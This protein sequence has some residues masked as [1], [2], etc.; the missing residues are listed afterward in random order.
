MA[1]RLKTYF[2]LFLLIGYL[3]VQGTTQGTSVHENQNVLEL[4]IVQGQTDFITDDDVLNSSIIPISIENDVNL[5]D[6]NNYTVSVY[7]NH[8]ARFADVSF[9]LRFKNPTG[10]E[11]ETFYLNHPLLSYE[12]NFL[13]DSQKNSGNYPWGFED[14]QLNYENMT[15]NNNNA[16]FSIFG[17]A[18]NGKFLQKILHLFH[19]FFVNFSL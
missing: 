4:H 13:T 9:M 6:L 11:M 16:N 3:A 14:I 19:Y 1:I 7:I 8:T 2:F 12:S 17:T 5:S 15:I 10:Q 18:L